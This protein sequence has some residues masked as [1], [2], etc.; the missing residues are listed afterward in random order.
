MNSLSRLH[1]VHNV[2]M[3]SCSEV[4]FVCYDMLP[5]DNSIIRWRLSMYYTYKLLYHK[6]YGSVK[7]YFNLNVSSEGNLGTEYG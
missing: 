2:F 5:R 6:C 3:I 4:D 7:Y 1:K